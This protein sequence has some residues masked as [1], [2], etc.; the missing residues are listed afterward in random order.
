M[1]MK[2]YPTNIK[3]EKPRPGMPAGSVRLQYTPGAKKRV[4]DTLL[5]HLKFYLKYPDLFYQFNPEPIGKDKR[6]K[7]TASIFLEIQQKLDV[8]RNARND[9]QESYIL[10]NNYVVEQTAE[11]MHKVKNLDAKII[12]EYINAYYIQYNDDEPK[13]YSKAIEIDLFE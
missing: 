3:T 6:A 10:R 9:I 12:D 11:K 7:D 2:E 1:V 4:A 13:F 8:W 5:E